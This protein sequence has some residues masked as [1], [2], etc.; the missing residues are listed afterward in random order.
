MTRSQ[1]THCGCSL[2]CK[3]HSACIGYRHE[4]GPCDCGR[5]I[6]QQTQVEVTEISTRITRIEV[7]RVGLAAYAE[8]IHCNWEFGLD[9]RDCSISP[10]YVY[11]RDMATNEVT[12]RIELGVLAHVTH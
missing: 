10:V 5:T 4:V 12:E 6:S 3:P 8:S 7:D 2:C 9:C 1:Q 11:F